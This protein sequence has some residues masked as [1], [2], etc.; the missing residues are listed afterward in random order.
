MGG[1]SRIGLSS[2]LENSRQ[3]FNQTLHHIRN[4]I[5][6]GA[7]GAWSDSQNG[8]F[9]F[10]HS[11]PNKSWFKISLKVV[12]P[13]VGYMKRLS[14]LQ[15]LSICHRSV[16]CNI[17]STFVVKFGLSFPNTLVDVAWKF[18]GHHTQ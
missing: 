2:H 1:G 9:Y 14:T 5:C 10:N 6:G 8:D 16:T 15:F 12:K 13:L 11:S 7:T 17:F 18:C 3:H 4:N